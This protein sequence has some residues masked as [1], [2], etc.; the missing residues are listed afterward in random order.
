MQQNIASNQGR[1]TPLALR[2]PSTIARLAGL[3]AAVVVTF[4][5]LQS[6]ST[7][8]MSAPATQ[9]AKANSIVV[10]AGLR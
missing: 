10:I 8:F 5:L 9:L 2:A 7:L 3:C 1:R 6:V 4:G